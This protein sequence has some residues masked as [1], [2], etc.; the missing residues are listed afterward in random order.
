[1]GTDIHMYVERKIAGSWQLIESEDL[2][3]NYA[4]FAI[5]ADVRNGYGFGGVQKHK[6]IEPINFPRGLPDDTSNEVRE[7]HG[8]W[9]MD[10]YSCSYLTAR[11]LLAADWHGERIEYTNGDQPTWAEEVPQIIPWLAKLKRLADGDPDSVR[12][13]FW[14]DS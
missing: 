2:G 7:E 10:A 13:V 11:E 3:R 9:D 8:V 4:L 14:F 6:P 12:A 1:M 5:L